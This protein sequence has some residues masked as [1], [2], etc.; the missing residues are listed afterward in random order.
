LHWFTGFLFYFQVGH[1]VVSGI[2]YKE[3]TS[4]AKGFYLGNQTKSSGKNLDLRP[5]R[6]NLFRICFANT[7]S[8]LNLGED[9]GYPK[10]NL[11]FTKVTDNPILSP[12]D[13]IH[14]FRITQEAIA[15][16]IKHGEASEVNTNLEFNPTKVILTIRDNGKGFNLHHASNEFMLENMRKRAVE[17]GGDLNLES[18][19]CGTNM[20]VSISL[21]ALKLRHLTY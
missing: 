13:T 6:S 12:K 7:Q 1:V 17:M 19:N 14:L 4:P 11:T 5:G 2:G 18:G 3:P 21:V 15:N 16:I 20:E 9:Q 10:P 8:L